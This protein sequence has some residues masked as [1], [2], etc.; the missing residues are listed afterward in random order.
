MQVY[1]IDRNLF[2][3]ALACYAYGSVL[4][5]DPCPNDS[6]S[7]ITAVT[8]LGTKVATYMV[9]TITVQSNS[10]GNYVLKRESCA[11]NKYKNTFD[12]LKR[13]RIVI[14]PEKIEFCTETK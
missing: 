13:Y 12:N 2:Q 11:A 10:D 7:V 1:L 3:K 14:Y 8:L 6:V 4:Y 9:N 5:Y